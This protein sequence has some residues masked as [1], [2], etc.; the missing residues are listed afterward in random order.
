V[1]LRVVSVR[2]L[3]VDALRLAREI[4]LSTY[5]ATFVLLSEATGST[6]VTADRRLARAVDR[7]ALIPGDEPPTQSRH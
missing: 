2:S 4:G 5:D 1:L 7:A 3:A 6:L